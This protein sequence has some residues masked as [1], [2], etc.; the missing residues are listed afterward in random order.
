MMPT[1]RSN[2]QNQPNTNLPEGIVDT[3]RPCSSAKNQLDMSKVTVVPRAT[4][5]QNVPRSTDSRS[6]YSHHSQRSVKA[7]RLQLQMDH[8]KKQQRLQVQRMQLEYEEKQLELELKIQMTEIEDEQDDIENDQDDLEDDQDDNQDY[9]N[10]NEDDYNNGNNSDRQAATRTREWVKSSQQKQPEKGQTYTDDFNSNAITSFMARQTIKQELPTFSGDPLEWPIFIAEYEN[11]SRIF[12]FSDYENIN[13]LRRALTGRAKECVQSLLL[14]PHNVHDIIGILRNRFGDCNHIV[15]VM[16]DKIRNFPVIKEDKYD[17]LITFFDMITNLI[18]TLL[19]FNDIDQIRNNLLF[20]EILEKVQV[21]Q[22]VAFIKHYQKI[23]SDEP[24]IIVFHEWLGQT[25]TAATALGFGQNRS[26]DTTLIVSNPV[27]VVEKTKCYCNY[28]KSTDHFITDCPKFKTLTVDK[29]WE[30]TSHNKLCIS[31]LGRNHVLKDCKR[32]KTCKAANCNF[33]HNFLLHKD[34][35][36]KSNTS[37]EIPK[38][39]DQDKPKPD[40]DKP[41]PDTNYNINFGGNKVLL[42]VIPVTLIGPQKSIDTY[43]LLDEASTISLID[44]QLATDLQLEGPI[45]P[46]KMQWTNNEIYEQANS[47]VVSVGIKGKEQMSK[48]FTL[49]KVKTVACLNLPLQTL[50]TGDMSQTYKFLKDFSFCSYYNAHP[51]ILIGQDNWS[52][53]VSRKLKYQSFQGPVASK[54]LLGWVVH[55]TVGMIR[56]IADT[57]YSFHVHECKGCD[58]PNDDLD[59][60]HN[61]VKSYWSIENELLTPHD[62]PTSLDDK[63]CLEIVNKTLKRVGDGFQCGLFWKSDDVKLPE[64]YKNAYSRLL[65][66]ERKIDKNPEYGKKYN[67]TLDS[68]IQKGYLKKINLEEKNIITPLTYYLPHFGVLNSN[69]PDKL[70]IVFD[71]ASKSHGYC[72]NDFLLPGPDLYSQL[73]SVLM[74]FREHKIAFVGDIKE[75]FLQIKVQETDRCA[76]RILWRGSNRHSEPDVYEIQVLFF[77][78]KC[79]PSIAQ[80]VRNRNAFEFKNDYG[81]ACDDIIA[82]HYMDDYLGGANDIGSAVKLIKDVIYVHK[83]G[84]FDMR[85][86]ISNSPEV[87]NQITDNIPSNQINKKNLTEERVLGLI[88]DHKK[89]VFTYNLKFSKSQFELLNNVRRPTKRDILKITMTI[90]DPLGY[91]SNILI[92]NKI[93]LQ[94]IWDSGIHW[95]DFITDEQ[96]DIWK[97]LSNNLNKINDIYI[98]RQMTTLPINLCNVQLHIFCDASKYAYATCAYLRFEYKDQ[99]EC[100]LISAKSRVAPLKPMSIP[101]LELQGSLLGARLSKS[102]KETLNVKI[103]ATF[104]WTDSEIVLYW[105]KTSSKRFKTFVAQRL[106]EIQEL[107]NSSEWRHVPSKV[108]PADKATKI[109]SFDSSANELWLVGPPFLRKT[110]DQWPLPKKTLSLDDSDDKDKE[111]VNLTTVQKHLFI[112]P[113]VMRFSNWMRFLRTTAWILRYLT[114]LRPNNKITF[115]NELTA[116][117]ISKAEIII[118]RTVQQ[119]AH[120]QEIENIKRNKPVSPSS[121][122]NCLPLFLCS[123]DLLRLRGRLNNLRDQEMSVDSKNPIILCKDHPITKL[124]VH[125]YHVQNC[126]IGTETVIANIRQ[127]FWIT[128]CR[129]TVKNVIRNCQHCKNRKAK[130]QAPLMGQLPTCRVVPTER[131]FLKVGID[132]FG[133]IEITQN[134]SHIKR[135]GVIFTC[136]TTRAVHLEIAEDLS[137]NAFMHVFRQFGCRRGF[138]TELYSDNGTNFRR[139]D[140]DIREIMEEWSNDKLTQ[141]LTTKGCNWYFNPPLSPHMGGAWERLIQS[142]KKYLLVLLK[143]RYPR[144]YTLKTLF[145]EIEFMMNS[146]PLLFI[147]SDSLSEPLTPNDLLIGPNYRESF[148]T[149]TIDSDLRLLN[150]WKASQRLADIFWLKWKKEYRQ[151]LICSRKWTKDNSALK[152]NDIVLIMEPDLPRNVWPKGKI[153]KTYPSK[154]GRVRIVDV[155]IKDNIYKRPTVKLIRLD[156]KPKDL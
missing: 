113:D 106:G 114:R 148:Y 28:C 156:V 150:M 138:P 3:P 67:E 84:G 75:M 44:E 126:H 76:Q 101:R 63:R 69:K 29:R 37:L 43:A 36:N 38:N 32:K 136:M 52:I 89:D 13:R 30:H 83:A 129:N 58:N 21:S 55:G 124:L 128:K 53:I 96:F 46:L 145:C 116:A 80:Q 103:D 134:R 79:S 60:L 49:R 107:T 110:Q 5:T 111:Y 14:V 65:L 118:F 108:N 137:C 112:L 90:F 149:D 22:R 2:K 122:L 153:V 6:S 34:K 74:N 27:K 26:K 102:I 23:K 133:P 121:G 78:A 18:Q 59:I 7:Q 132:Y 45:S 68:Y 16:I 77:G 66:C 85:N 155:R 154:D 10:D 141:F 39:P 123:D 147:P 51:K 9:R 98:P 82:K 12:N 50:S 1:T 117:E 88:W 109:S 64:S 8:L 54:T 42:K 56:E 71:A 17:K 33:N 35:I 135:Y 41:N 93:L 125:Y 61:L 31:C 139:A 120:H 62:I 105:L 25:I 73:S 140:K 20:E 4:S 97:I 92:S 72:L 143:E 127:R 87:L 104:M 152:E 95:D 15:K 146:R 131:A 151:F 57:N 47:K 142:V 86:W 19:S 99:V 115:C 119:D 144:E 11:S 81:Q 94:A 40:Q 70:R 91:L 130:P 100:T 24:K 48:V